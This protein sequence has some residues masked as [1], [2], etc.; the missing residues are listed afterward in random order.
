[1]A[2]NPEQTARTGRQAY[3][4]AI[5]LAAE[6]APRN[7]RVS[8]LPTNLRAQMLEAAH[9]YAQIAVAHSNLA[10]RDKFTET[11]R[12]F[13]KL[14]RSQGVLSQFEENVAV[15]KEDMRDAGMGGFEQEW[16]PDRPDPEALNEPD[17][18]DAS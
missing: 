3:E 6:V 7:G 9:L 4:L 12:L 17:D 13:A 15:P 18:D 11:N 14:L 1:M 10:L 2:R 5:E 8:P 16:V